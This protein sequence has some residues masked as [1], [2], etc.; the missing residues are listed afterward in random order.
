MTDR[1]AAV[2]L[3]GIA[4]LLILGAGEAQRLAVGVLSRPALQMPQKVRALSER[5]V[6]GRAY[7]ISL[8]LVGIAVAVV[9]VA[10]FFSDPA[11]K[12]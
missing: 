5:A 10:I 11:P 7:R 1:L 3:L 9:A 6:S 2:V 4:L 8:R 12:G